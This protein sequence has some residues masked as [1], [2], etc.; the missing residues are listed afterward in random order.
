MFFKTNE[1]VRY[2][3]YLDKQAQVKA[4][5]QAQQAQTQETKAP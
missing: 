5:Q 2:Q 4:A 1:F 3:Q